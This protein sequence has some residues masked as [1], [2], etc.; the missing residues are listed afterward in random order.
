MAFLSS[1]K[2]ETKNFNL[3]KSLGKEKIKEIDETTIQ[4]ITFDGQHLSTT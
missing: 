1:I 2:V 4:S 3:S